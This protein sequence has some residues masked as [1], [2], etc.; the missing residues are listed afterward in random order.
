MDCPLPFTALVNDTGTAGARTQLGNN[1]R[2]SR[3]V[4]YLKPPQ[5]KKENPHEDPI[6]LVG[7]YLY[8]DEWLMFHRTPCRY[9]GSYIY[10]YYTQN[11]RY[12]N[13]S[14]WKIPESSALRSPPKKR[15]LGGLNFPKNLWR[16]NQKR[17]IPKKIGGAWIGFFNI[18]ISLENMFLQMLLWCV[19][20]KLP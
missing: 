20:L 15:S 2:P 6:K 3:F 14:P 8:I 4:P 1:S 18:K 5:K 7:M 17:S 16:L 12:T 13:K 19:F 10:I 9:I 11:L